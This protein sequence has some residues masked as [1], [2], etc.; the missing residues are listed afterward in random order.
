MDTPLPD[1]D[2][3]LDFWELIN[4]A[5][6]LSG[7]KPNPRCVQDPIPVRYQTLATVRSVG[8]GIRLTIDR[9][10]RCLWF[11][12]APSYSL[13]G[14]KQNSRIAQSTRPGI[15]Y[16][17]IFHRMRRAD[18]EKAV[19]RQAHQAVPSARLKRLLIVLDRIRRLPCPRPS[20]GFLRHRREV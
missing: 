13:L 4:D 12:S 1:A 2:G 17:R 7:P 8:C 3:V 6:D 20:P 9:V 18:L 10:S 15:V 11:S 16:T 19:D 5:I 14:T